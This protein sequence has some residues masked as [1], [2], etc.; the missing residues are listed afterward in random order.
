MRAGVLVLVVVVGLTG[1]F[2]ERPPGDGFDAG[3][4]SA[5]SVPD[6]SLDG[7]AQATPDGAAGEVTIAGPTA[8]G[9]WIDIKLGV[10]HACGIWRDQ[11]GDEQIYCFG[12]N[13]K[14]E[15]GAEANTSCTLQ[16][17][18]V[19]PGVVDVGDGFTGIGH[20]GTIQFLGAD[21]PEAIMNFVGTQEALAI[22]ESHVCALTLGGNIECRGQPN[23]GGEEGELGQGSVPPPP[24]AAWQAVFAGNDMSCAL[25]SLNHAWCWGVHLERGGEVNDGVVTRLAQD[26]YSTLALGRP[27]LCGILRGRL[28]CSHGWQTDGGFYDAP[29]DLQAPPGGDGFVDVQAC[30]YHACALMC[31]GDP[32][33]DGDHPADQLWCWGS[34]LSG[35]VDP[36]G[37]RE[38]IEH[39][40]ASLPGRWRRV[41]VAYVD[42]QNSG[43]RTCAITN[44]GALRCWGEPWCP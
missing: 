1:C 21:R 34:N 13:T 26:D 17:Q 9:A 44:A 30:Q 5:R 4:G 14:G 39:P 24:D 22:G 12:S 3:D 31:E 29:H 6:G 40:Q 7:S 11:A 42:N 33:P 35:Q 38:F 43:G 28:Q 36:V 25:D 37:A 10:R 41:S 15:L 20:N 19:G 27:A 18:H 2:Y 32:C 23:G 8:Q 16:P